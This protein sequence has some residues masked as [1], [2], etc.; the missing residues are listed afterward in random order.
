AALVATGT[1]HSK[2]EAEQQAARNG[3]TAR[4]WL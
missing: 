1:G 4:G 2:Q 3:L